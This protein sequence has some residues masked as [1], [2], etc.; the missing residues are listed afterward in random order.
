MALRIYILWLLEFLTT[1]QRPSQLGGVRWLGADLSDA[2]FLLGHTGPL[3]LGQSNAL[4]P[5][6]ENTFVLGIISS[7]LLHLFPSGHFGS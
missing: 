3:Y 5:Q 2:F 1:R 4:Q 7:V 6:T